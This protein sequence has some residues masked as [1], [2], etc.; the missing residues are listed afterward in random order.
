MWKKDDQSSTCCNTMY[1]FLSK[2]LHHFRDKCNV[3][4]IAAQT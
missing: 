1:N 4:E 2:A 3:Q